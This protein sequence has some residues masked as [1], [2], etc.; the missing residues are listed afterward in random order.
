MARS[1]FMA[2]PFCVEAEFSLLGLTLIVMQL[3]EN[4]YQLALGVN[5]RKFSLCFEKKQ[6]N[7]I[8]RN[9]VIAVVKGIGLSVEEA[10]FLV[11]FCI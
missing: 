7:L 10:P 4:R 11:F 5:A 6:D 9:R 1:V 3:N 2:I 8:A